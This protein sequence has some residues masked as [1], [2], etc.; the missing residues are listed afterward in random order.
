MGWAHCRRKLKAKAVK[1]RRNV[2]LPLKGTWLYMQ[3]P[4]K[5]I[6]SSLINEEV[7]AGANIEYK[8]PKNIEYRYVNDWGNDNTPLH[9]ACLLGF[10]QIV[11]RLL[12]LNAS[13]NI[14]NS[15]L[16]TPLH[17]AIVGEHPEIAVLLLE[18]GADPHAKNDIK[19][20]P[21]AWA[22]NRG[23][24]ELVRLL[25]NRGADP[26]AKISVSN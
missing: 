19:D 25:L 17:F 6:L 26:N 16:S 15:C 3:Q 4:K 5:A 18:R 14:T 20:T 1:S 11:V 24:L 7:E 12:E 22:S 2:V 23:L 21:L 10:M 9:I 8:N 13:T